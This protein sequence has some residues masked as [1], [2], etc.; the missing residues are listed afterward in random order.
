MK[1]IAT[2]LA[3]FVLRAS[4]ALAQEFSPQEPHLVFSI[5]VGL[6]SGSRL[7][8]L[9]KHPQPV[10]GGTLNNQ[11]TLALGRVLRP[12]IVAGLAATYFTSPRFGWTAEVTYFGLSS[13]QRCTGPVVYQPEV[14]RINTQA[15]DRAQGLHVATSAVGI[16][17]G[18]TFRFFPD[19]RVEPFVRAV[20]GL[21]LLG[22]S[23][24]ATSG[25]VRSAQ[26]QTAD[27]VCSLT[28]IKESKTSQFTFVTSLSGGFS[29]ALSPAYRV[30]FE[31]RDVITSLPIATG[32]GT[33]SDPVVVPT[34]RAIKHI[35]V[36]TIGMDIILE[37][38]HTRRY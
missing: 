4:A 35:P 21:G 29:F 37:R 11:D 3:V 28:L 32:N 17:G 31:G 30:R 1:R 20:A 14:D 7:W 13:E 26:C 8:V 34:G 2:V 25:V 36:F 18:A 27:N 10:V 16:L 12:G 22:N 15:C 38:R 5:S 33:S 24:I 23:Y 6:S 9:P 19:Q